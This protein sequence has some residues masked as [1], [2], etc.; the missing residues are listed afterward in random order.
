MSIDSIKPYAKAI[1]A[2]ITPG[3]AALVAAVQ[4]ASPAGSD[5]SGPEWVGIFAVCVLTSG[6][7]F[8]TPN[9][10]PRGLKQAES[11]QPP[12]ASMG[13]GLGGAVEGVA[14]GI[15]ASDPTPAPPKPGDDEPKPT[16]GY[17][18]GV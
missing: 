4:D 8:A 13:D 18:G 14:D 1:V 3:V 12:E 15:Y 2:F 5:I 11:V 9:R 17:W 6:A 7:V 10:D 16:G